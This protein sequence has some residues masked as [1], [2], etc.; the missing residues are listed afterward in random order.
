MEKYI[1]LYPFVGQFKKYIYPS[2]F[3]SSRYGLIYSLKL[4]SPILNWYNNISLNLSL[5]NNLNQNTQI[6]YY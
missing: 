1:Y 4:V 2:M 5:R 3:S 6:F